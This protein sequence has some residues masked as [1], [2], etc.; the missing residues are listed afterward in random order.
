MCETFLGDPPT[1]I[2]SWRSA[3]RQ[4]AK[5]VAHK[6]DIRGQAGYCADILRQESTDSWRHSVSILVSIR[7]SN[8]W[9][10]NSVRPLKQ[11]G[12]I[13]MRHSARPERSAQDKYSPPWIKRNGARGDKSD[14]LDSILVSSWWVARRVQNKRGEQGILYETLCM[15]A[16]NSSREIRRQ[17]VREKM[18]LQH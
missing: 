9:V 2:Q 18:W 13:L 8:W 5:K 12:E 16:K 7:I 17:H 6:T 10:A 15:P 4:N 3:R 14:N 11:K 1:Q